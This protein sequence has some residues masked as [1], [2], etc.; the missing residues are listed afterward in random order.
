MILN[1]TIR[2]I[3]DFGMFIDINVH[4]DALCHISEVSKSYVS[5]IYDLYNINEIVKVKVISVD[6]DKKRIGVSLK[7]VN[8]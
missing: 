2:N 3:M 5:N 8:N 4:Q 6:I 7:Q 1:G